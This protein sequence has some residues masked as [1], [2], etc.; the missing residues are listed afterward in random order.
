MIHN[1]EFC[2]KYIE[3]TE[4]TFPYCLEIDNIVICL[5]F[6]LWYIMLFNAY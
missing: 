2:I 5:I 4:Q 3:G 6:T 1:K